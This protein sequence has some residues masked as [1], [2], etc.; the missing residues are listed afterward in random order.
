MVRLAV[1]RRVYTCCHLDFVAE[2]LAELYRD[3]HELR[4][5]DLIDQPKRLRHFGARLRPR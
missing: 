2:S 5:L 3:R 4:P 1:P